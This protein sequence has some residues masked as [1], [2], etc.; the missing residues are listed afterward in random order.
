[1]AEEPQVS[2]PQRAVRPDDQVPAE[3]RQRQGAGPDE[4]G[5]PGLRQAEGSH[6]RPQ[7]HP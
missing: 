2:G 3:D 1:M 6:A 4:A 7:P 5:Q